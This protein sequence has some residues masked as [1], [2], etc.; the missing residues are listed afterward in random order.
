MRRATSQVKEAKNGAAQPL[1]RWGWELR[2]P[3]A[4][5]PFG[6]PEQCWSANRNPGGKVLHKEMLKKW[7]ID[8]ADWTWFTEFSVEL[9][10]HDLQTIQ[11]RGFHSGAG[12]VRYTIWDVA[13]LQAEM[14]SQESSSFSKLHG[15]HGQAMR[16]AGSICEHDMSHIQFVLTQRGG[17]IW[18]TPF[19][20]RHFAASYHCRGQDP[21]PHLLNCLVPSCEHTN[22]F[23][24]H[25]GC[26]FLTHIQSVGYRVNW[27]GLTNIW[28]HAATGPKQAEGCTPLLM[29]PHTW[30][31]CSYCRWFWVLGM[32]KSADSPV[33][34]SFES[35]LCLV[36]SRWSLNI[37]RQYRALQ[38]WAPPE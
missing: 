4:S 16:V 19:H 32:W 11:L 18:Q 22:S 5:L 23:Y 10:S 3:S 17:Q 15:L 9:L 36:P 37:P 34:A 28:F 6:A 7:H 31:T 14:Y 27:P 29:I 21:S 8:W 12:F 25:K 2:L 26:W 35:L 33:Q 24:F 30:V 1:I 38:S 20:G 13:T